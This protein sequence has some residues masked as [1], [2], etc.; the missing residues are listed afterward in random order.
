MPASPGTWSP[1]Q[2]IEGGHYIPLVA[3]RANLKIVTWAKDWEMT[4]P[5]FQKYNDE[6]V[7]YVSLEALKNNKSPEGFNAAQLAADLAGLK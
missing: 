6:S 5:F 1:S 4:V 7:A 3:R 2:E